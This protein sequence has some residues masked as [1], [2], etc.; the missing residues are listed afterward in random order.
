MGG[1][2]FSTGTVFLVNSTFSGN[3]AMGGAGGGTSQVDAELRPA[4]GSA[5][6]NGYGGA[7]YSSFDTWVSN[8]TLTGNGA[9][10]GMGGFGSAFRPEEMAHPA[11]VPVAQSIVP[12]GL[13]RKI[14]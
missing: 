14:H 3:R 1:A 5:G 4:N 12:A 9:S 2:L 8:C 7:I 6:G 13:P 10:G 11:Q